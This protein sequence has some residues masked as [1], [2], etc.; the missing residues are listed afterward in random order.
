MATVE[1]RRTRMIRRALALVFA[2]AM[3]S[4]PL[5]VEAQPAGKTSRI[6]VL[7]PGF[8]PPG[9]LEAFRDGLRDLGYV[10]GKTVTIEW[11]FAEGK[12][13][14]L[15]TLADELVRLK[16]DVIFA[17]NTPAAQAA[18]KATTAVP[19]VI[20]RLADPVG[21][22]LVPSISRPG[23]NIT[24]LSSI[25]DEV[26]AKR[27]EFLKEILPAL[28]RVAALWNAGNSGAR[29]VVRVIELAAPQLGLQ[30]QLIPVR[31]SNEFL[32]AFEAAVRGR[33]QALF[34]VDDVLITAHKVQFLKLAA[35]HALP[36]V[37][38]YKEFAEAGALMT[39]GTDVPYEYRRAAHY[40][41]RILKGAKPAD[42]PIEQPTRFLRIVNL[43]TAKTL[44]LSVPSLQL[45]RADEVI[46]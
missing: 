39:Y 42:L 20:A 41:D 21:S 32:G 14:R 43:K 46:E 7:S 35:K 3:F 22:G 28:S 27:L 37:A 33:A 12:N 8:P 5:I 11:R 4:P 25:T 31:D 29:N 30:L 16:V 19:I 17:V 26:A 2:L 44:G 6:G 15:M 13:E 34:V 23:G 24:G 36:V 45:F 1:H 18:K 9:L 40:V 38:S 10:E